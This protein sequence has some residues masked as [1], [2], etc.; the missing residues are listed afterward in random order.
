MRLTI[1][2]AA[3]LAALLA[4]P[5]GLA[6]A[7]GWTGPTI[8][9]L[10]TE[11]RLSETSGLAAASVRPGTWWTINDG[12]NT[13]ELHLV[14]D[15]GH[16]IASFPVAGVANTDWEDLSAF[17]LGG[18]RYLLIADTGDNGGIRTEL[19][20]HVVAEP[21]EVVDGARLPVAWSIRFRWPDGP[22]DCEAVAVDAA[23]GD[24]LLVSKKRVPAELLRLP[25]RPAEG[26]PQVA[27]R[28]G[29]LGG[30]DQPTADDLARNPVYGRYRSQ[31]TAADLSPDGRTLAVLN[32]RALYLYTRERDATWATA[33]R[34]PERLDFTWMPQAEAIAF[35]LDGHELRVAGEQTPSPMLRFR[36]E[37]KGPDALPPGGNDRGP[38]AKGSH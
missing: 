19:S 37:A 6:H 30:I 7:T 36:R 10:M 15:K 20:L 5:A 8:T 18:R 14:D 31:V 32:Y 34:Q 22:R 33:L 4:T 26:S 24:V 2:T 21:R 35:S 25:L 9:G 1:P 17:T 3:L 13:P 28:I 38:H 12:G 11:A 16:R 27:E 29:L 23:R